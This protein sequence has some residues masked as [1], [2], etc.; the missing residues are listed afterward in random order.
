MDARRHHSEERCWTAQQTQSGQA[1]SASCRLLDQWALVNNSSEPLIIPASICATF[2]ADYC[3]IPVEL[4]GLRPTGSGDCTLDRW[5][6]PDGCLLPVPHP[7]LTPLLGRWERQSQ[8]LAVGPQARAAFQ[9]FLPYFQAE[10][11][12]L[13]DA[14]LDQE[15]QIMDDILK[16]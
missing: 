4:Y 16:A 1:Q 8:K 6:L 9:E 5:L 12:A 2:P 7:V 15:V 13:G 11:A 10:E 3:P 14:S